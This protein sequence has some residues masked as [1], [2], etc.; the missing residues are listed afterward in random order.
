MIVNLVVFTMHYPY[1]IG[2]NFLEEEIR[3]A[4]KIFDDILIVS[5]AK[6]TEKLN[7]YIPDNAKVI[8]LRE[9]EDCVT[10]Y[11]VLL[12][13]AF[14]WSTWK[15]LLEG[16]KERG[17]VKATKILKHI[18]ATERHI[19]Y[20]QN[21]ECYWLTGVFSSKDTFYYS[22]WLSSAALYLAR[23]KRNLNGISISR[24]HRYECFFSCGYIPW[25]KEILLNIDQIFSISERG[26]MDIL[27]HYCHIV[28][29]LSKRMSVARLGV[30]IPVS[31]GGKKNSIKQVTIVSCSQ[32]I[33]RKRLDLIIDS[34]SLCNSINIHWLHFGDGELMEQIKKY[35]KQ[36]LSNNNRITYEFFGRVYNKTIL[37]YYGKHTIYLFINCSDSEGI[38]VSA[39]EAMA[40][41]IPVIARNVGGNY[42]LVDNNCGILLPETITP[43]D[44]YRAIKTV[45]FSE[46]G[47]TYQDRC[48]N[49]HNK[50]AK[51]FSAEKNYTRFFETIQGLF[52]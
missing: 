33:F 14:C 1:G 19:A 30:V 17:F 3:I 32:V 48:M 46:D 8:K 21:N 34:L 52:G 45:L 44:L 41:G 51:L 36:K 38:P 6:D 9:S 13:F 11:F 29:G 4:E 26:C 25:R 12:K 16:C 35:A 42:E 10:E 49:A 43:N 20:L 7:K 37:H 2:E 23:N 28:K 22:Y 5:Y 50:V 31:I 18:L 15:E 24:A 39:M 27:E 40:H 47:V